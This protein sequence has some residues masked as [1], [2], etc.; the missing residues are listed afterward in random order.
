MQPNWQNR[1]IMR[2]GS[3]GTSA[4]STSHA[5]W[6]TTAWTAVCSGCAGRCAVSA[7]SWRRGKTT[8]AHLCRP[9]CYRTAPSRRTFEGRLFS[10]RV[11]ALPLDQAPF[12]PPG[13]ILH[14]EIPARCH[15][16]AEIADEM[17]RREAER[18]EAD[19]E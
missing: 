14:D 10:P 8:R 7:P 17:A 19:A 11:G 3:Q 16:A 15:M 12:D 5:K 2:A 4:S 18:A 9:R 6:F 13:R 1:T